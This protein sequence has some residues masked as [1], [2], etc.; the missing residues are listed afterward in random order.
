MAISFTK[1]DLPYGW[2][3]NMAR[4]PVE[5]S[6]KRWRTTEALFQAL[7][8][9]DEAI[10]EE[11]RATSSPMSAK[12]TAKK[13]IRLGR[14]IVVP[15]S[16][17]DLGNMLLVLRLKLAQHPGLRQQLLD[18]GDEEIIEDCGK[19]QGGSGKF[20]G[21]AFKDGRWVG[22]NTLGKLWMR[23]REELRQ[24]SRLSGQQ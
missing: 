21:A 23:I 19:R 14:N 6:G 2:C 8:F 18:T 16:E 10:R 4:Y 24:E 15:Q 7:R 3:G 11:I 12:W 9:D 20:W 17:Q 13:Y 22:E 1:V 5:Y